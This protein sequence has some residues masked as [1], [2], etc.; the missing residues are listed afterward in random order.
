MQDTSFVQKLDA[1]LACP[2]KV[3]FSDSIDLVFLV[4]AAVVAIG[5]FVLLFLPQLPLRTSRASRPSSR[6][7]AS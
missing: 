2:F 5:F 1:A 4:A 3:A 7:P 6:G